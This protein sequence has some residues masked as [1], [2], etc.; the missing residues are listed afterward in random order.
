M[1][2]LMQK[3]HIRW[4][5]IALQLW[6]CTE[7]AIAWDNGGINYILNEKDKT[8]I[9]GTDHRNVPPTLDIPEYIYA[10][11]SEYPTISYD[12][13]KVVGIG[14]ESFKMCE[15]LKSIS[16]PRTVTQIGNSAFEGCSNLS[17][18]SLPEG[19]VSIGRYAFVFCSNLSSLTI[20]RSVNQ[21]GFNVF[22]N[23]KINPL[24]FEGTY[25]S[26]PNRN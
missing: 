1:K 9:V 11:A 4:L 12:R 7:S 6:M 17:S 3:I 25:T 10:L 15:T 22:N 20:P 24:I 26:S 13:Y 8:C 2:R 23:C 18:I 14:D 16:L 19:L 5:L 21:F